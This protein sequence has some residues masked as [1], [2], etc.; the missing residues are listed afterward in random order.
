[1][2]CPK[3]VA[4]VLLLV[5]CGVDATSLEPQLLVPQDVEIGWDTSF[6]Q[7]DDGRAVLV[8][9]DVM[10]YAATGEPV[11][12][13]RVGLAGS[14]GALLARADAIV[15][16]AADDP[17]DGWWDSWRDRYFLFAPGEEPVFALDLETD[18]TG[19]ARGWAFVDRF[20]P[21]EGP[22]FAPAQVTVTLGDVEDS[23]LLLPR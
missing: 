20:A 22:G 15:T 14:S 7:R 9:I 21:D 4:A 6:N 16:L 3:A 18:A 8:P 13:A 5:A 2:T 10:V 12:G 17:R 1:M 11:E 19:L 23:L